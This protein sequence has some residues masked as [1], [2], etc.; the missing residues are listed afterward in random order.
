MM[1]K[2]VYKNISSLFDSKSKCSDEIEN[3]AAEYVLNR[4]V[5]SLYYNIYI[6]DVGLNMKNNKN[7]SAKH[8]A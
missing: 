2:K 7:I 1:Y 4:I 3:F 5:I 8:R 6:S